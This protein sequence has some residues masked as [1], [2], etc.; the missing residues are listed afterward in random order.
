MVVTDTDWESCAEASNVGDEFEEEEEEEEKKKKEK[1]VGGGE[2]GGGGDDSSSSSSSKPLQNTKHRL[3][4][5]AED[6]Q[7]GDRIKEGT[8]IFIHLSVQQKV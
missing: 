7:Y 6:Y 1:E 3:Q 2:G 4:Q 8:K 5:V